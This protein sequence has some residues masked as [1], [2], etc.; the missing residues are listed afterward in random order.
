MNS[1]TNPDTNSVTN[2]ATA[3][4]TAVAGAVAAY[5]ISLVAKAEPGQEVVLQLAV[6]QPVVA[7]RE[8][9]SAEKLLAEPG[10]APGE[11]TRIYVLEPG[12]DL[13]MEGDWYKLVSPTCSSITLDP[14]MKD[15]QEPPADLQVRS[16]RVL[17][18]PDIALVICNPDRLNEILVGVVYFSYFVKEL[19]RMERELSSSWAQVRQDMHF[20]H[21]VDDSAFAEQPRINERSRWSYGLRADYARIEPFIDVVP[22]YVPANSRRIIQELSTHTEILA[23]FKVIDEQLEVFEDTYELANDR[24]LEYSNYRGEFKLEVIIIVVL[25]IELA[26]MAAEFFL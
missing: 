17:W 18:R 16:D 13:S 6:P 20:I 4:V 21:Q 3:P 23:R 25:I 26:F 24:I 10:A 15:A 1:V 19:S 12:A 5:R 11:L 9:I 2:P 7:V 14:A 8:S 22:N